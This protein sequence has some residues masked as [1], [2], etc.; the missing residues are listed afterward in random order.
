MSQKQMTQLSINKETKPK[1]IHTLC[2]CAFLFVTMSLGSAVNTGSTQGNIPLSFKVKSKE[3]IYKDSVLIARKKILD[4][5]NIIK[6][7][8]NLEVE[9][10]KKQQKIIKN[11]QV[12]VNRVN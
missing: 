10:V 3:A 4:S 8:I 5:I 11:E 6:K 2:L 12:S 9:N 1:L 7:D